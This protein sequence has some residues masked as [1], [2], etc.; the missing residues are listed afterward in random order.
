[1]HY[2]NQHSFSRVT[3]MPSV[4]IFGSFGYGGTSVHRRCN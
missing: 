1:L 4:T 3:I 2:V